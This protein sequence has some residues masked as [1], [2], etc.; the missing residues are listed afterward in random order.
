MK[1]GKNVTGGIGGYQFLLEYVLEN[2]LNSRRT[3][4][5]QVCLFLVTKAIT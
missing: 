1:E 3:V 2:V 5:S 4:H